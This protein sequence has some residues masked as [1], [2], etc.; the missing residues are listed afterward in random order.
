MT[1]AKAYYCKSAAGRSQGAE[2]ESSASSLK[3]SVAS[4]R[5]SLSN[6]ATAIIFELG[7]TAFAADL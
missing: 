6:V 5:R 7:F 3:V 2:G 4:A 1:A